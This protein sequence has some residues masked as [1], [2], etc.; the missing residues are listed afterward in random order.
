MKSLL[1]TEARIVVMDEV[2]LGYV[3]PAQPFRF[4]PLSSAIGGPDP[5]N[6]AYPAGKMREAVQADFDRFRVC[7][8]GFLP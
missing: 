7:S 6:G 8:R 2:S 3:C 1:G 5:K 4:W